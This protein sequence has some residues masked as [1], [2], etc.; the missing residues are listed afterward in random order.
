MGRWLRQ[1]TK[2]SYSAV[3]LS[4]L[5]RSD[6]RRVLRTGAVCTISGSVKGIYGDAGRAK[7]IQA[8]VMVFMIMGQEHPI[9]MIDVFMRQHIQQQ[10]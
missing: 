10:I 1:P 7:G 5:C 9:Q 6:D 8:A 4:A 3:T 2:K